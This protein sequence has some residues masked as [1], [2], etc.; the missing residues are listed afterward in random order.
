MQAVI[1]RRLLINYRLDPDVAATMIPAPFEPQLLNGWAVVGICLIRLAHMRPSGLP[2]RLGLTSENAAHRFAVQWNDG[3]GLRTGVYIPTRHSAAM[4]NVAVGDR[5]FPGRHE[6]ADFQSTETP[7]AIAVAFKA[8]DART[9]VDAYVGIRD[10]LTDS[11]LFASTAEASNFFQA[12]SAGFSPTRRSARLDGLELHTS[13]W[14]IEAADIHHVRSSFFDDRAA[15]PA[16]TIHL[17]SALVMRDVAVEWHSVGSLSPNHG[18]RSLGR[19]E[20][21]M[22]N[23]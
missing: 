7:D 21:L 16:G 23:V 15:F 20:R 12:G 6:R 1:E 8:R 9:F 3:A 19:P 22:A 17:D 11:E 2:A 18:D 5:L 13:A 14:R 4:V 10:E